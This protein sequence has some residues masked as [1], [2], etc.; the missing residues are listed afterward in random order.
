MLTDG[1]K[2]LNLSEWGE[3]CKRNRIHQQTTEPHSPWQNPAEL[4]G[5]ITK[6]RVRH[7]MKSTNSPIRLWDYCWEYINLLKSSTA[8][9]HFML[10]GVTPYEKVYSH[11]PN[12]TELV[13]YKWFDWL[14]YYNP[15]EN[16]K[17]KLGR[18]LGPA[19]HVGEVHTYY[20]LT[21]KGNVINRSTTRPLTKNELETAHPC[22]I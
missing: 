19:H 3:I 15:A 11:P 18:W 16:D 21:E 1:A 14:W 2:E 8:T 5:G 9:N 12:I 22:G 13:Q 4:N 7:M 6:R 10:D 17:E 20:I